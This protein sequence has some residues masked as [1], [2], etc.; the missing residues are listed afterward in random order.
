MDKK[1]INSY[2]VDEAIA[3]LEEI[4]GLLENAGMDVE[5]T[6]VLFEEGVSL[7]RLCRE[8]LSALEERVK[9][10]SKSQDGE[11][12]FTPFEVNDNEQ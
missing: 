1:D 4:Q 3:R 10:L 7:Y 8:K 2:T 11:I 5:E 6:V 12:I 9:I